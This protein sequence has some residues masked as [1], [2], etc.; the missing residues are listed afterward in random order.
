MPTLIYELISVELW[1]EKVFS[2][3]VNMNFEPKNTFIIYLIV[4]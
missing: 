2:E 4:F 1:K 3:L